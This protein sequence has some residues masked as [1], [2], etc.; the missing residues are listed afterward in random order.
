M[1]ISL[2][3]LGLL[4]LFAIA[5]AVGFYL[6][7]VLR[8]LAAVVAQIHG[9]LAD[10]RESIDSTLEVLPELLTNSNE[11]V[12]G[13]R[14]TVETANT[15]VACLEDNI[16]DTADKV[17]ETIDT[18]MVYARCASEIVRAV[19]GAFAKTDAR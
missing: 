13:V 5:L 9:M 4:I 3:D 7:A 1:Y 2:Y 8:K 12:A 18:A 11:V 15:A 6:I 16:V 10:N 14:K 19:V 17:Q